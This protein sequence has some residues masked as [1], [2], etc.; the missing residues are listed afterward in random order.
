MESSSSTV[1]C[2]SRPEVGSSRM[3]ICASFIRISASANRWRIPR[4]KV[5]T[6]LSMT[7]GKPTLS[8]A[9]L[10]RSSRSTPFEPDQAGGVAQIVAGGE[11]VIKAD[12]VG[13]VADPALDLE[14]FARRIAA[15]HADLPVGDVGQAEHHQDGRGLAGAVR[16]EHAEDLAAR[17]RER[18]AVDDRDP[19]VALGEVLRLYD[20]FR[21]R[22]PN[23]AT[24]PTMTSKATPM[25]SAPMMPHMVEVVTATRK[26]CDADS[27]RADA[28][29][30]VT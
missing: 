18:D 5:C 16:A 1:A 4:E 11:V 9:A 2:G 25:S 13:H 30:V 12:G 27:P 14:R 3:A 29:R 10:I 17:D 19:A 24:A 26:V 23:L 8:S 15:E 6:G 22:R 7:S 20:I 28:R 21:H